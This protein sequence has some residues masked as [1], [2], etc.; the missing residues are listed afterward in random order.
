MSA[1]IISRLRDRSRRSFYG[2]RIVAAGFIINAFGVG[3]FFYGFSTFFNPMIAEFGWSRTLMSGV[4]SLSRLEGGIEG[5]IAGWLTDRFG[6]RK[7]LICGVIIAGF[8]FMLLRTVNSIVS[9]YLIFGL[10]M[11]IGFNLG[12]MH[13]TSAAVAK[14]FVKKRGRALSFLIVGNGVG[15][16]ILVP[17]IAWLITQYDWR[18]ATIILGIATLAIPLPLSFI[19]RST[20]E[21][22]GL[23]PDGEVIKHKDTTTELDYS[24]ASSADDALLDEVNLTVREAL[25][26]RAFWVYAISMILR[27]CILSSIVI[28]QIPHLTDIGIPYQTASNVLGLMVLMSIPGRFLFGWLGDRFSKR[29]LLFLSCILQGI[30]IFIFINASTLPL[31]YLF[32]V[33]YGLGYGG[34]IPLTVALRADLFGR[35]NYATIAGI[36]MSL[37]MI[38]TVTAPLFAGY[39][40]DTTQSYSL[41][42]YIFIAMIVLSGFFFLMIPPTSQ[43]T[44]QT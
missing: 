13:A 22:M 18:V 30:G 6:A 19:V 16:A 38:G 24:L 44:R 39:L 36:T 28:H 10:V 8:G 23:Q 20:P 9:L 15:G 7:M 5:P 3:T 42:F 2:W 34:A 4:F 31:L 41:A 1:D 14:W 43:P 12:F 27:A 17:V 25:K 35:T 26:T 11:S 40:Y 37:A 32:V 21:E 29:F 33:V